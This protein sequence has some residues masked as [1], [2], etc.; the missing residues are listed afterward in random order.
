M[1]NINGNINNI[2]NNSY[3]AN[4]N[5]P[6]NNNGNLVTGNSNNGNLITG[7][8][9]TGNSNNGNLVTGNIVNPNNNNQP[10][11]EETNVG[12]SNQENDIYYLFVTAL[13]DNLLD[14]VLTY[15]SFFSYDDTFVMEEVI[16]GGH[17][18]LINLFMDMGY[19]I[20]MY[21]RN[22]PM[23]Y[24]ILD[25]ENELII[26]IINQIDYDDY[27]QDIKNKILF[28]MCRVYPNKMD[29]IN[30]LLEYSYDINYND[31][32]GNTYY[33]WA[34]AK[35]CLPL[36]NKLLEL[37]CN[38]E[39]LTTEQMKGIDYAFIYN[40]FDLVRELIK[41]GFKLTFNKLIEKSN[42]NHME[43][44][45]LIRDCKCELT[46]HM[47]LSAIQNNILPFITYLIDTH[48]HIYN[49]P[50]LF[51][52][53]KKEQ[54]EI[55][56]NKFKD[57]NIKDEHE[58]N[59]LNYA[60]H[61]MRYDI[62][63]DFFKYIDLG[64][65]NKK[66]NTPL[67]CLIN[68]DCIGCEKQIKEFAN[69]PGVNIFEKNN[70]N[71]TAIDYLLLY[72]RR[73]LAEEILDHYQSN[74]TMFWDNI[75][76]DIKVGLICKDRSIWEKILMDD[77]IDIKKILENT[78]YNRSMN[79]ILELGLIKGQLTEEDILNYETN[80]TYNF[81]DTYNLLKVLI[82]NFDKL[83]NKNILTTTIIRSYF[84]LIDYVRSI[85]LDNYYE[86]YQET[87]IEY[88]LEHLNSMKNILYVVN[89]YYSKEKLMQDIK[90]IKN[91]EFINNLINNDEI[92]KIEFLVRNGY[93]LKEDMINNLLSKDLTKLSKDFILEIIKNIKDNKILLDL[94]VKDN[95]NIMEILFNNA[96][97]KEITENCVICYGIENE[98]GYYYQCCHKH[99]YHF[100][101]LIP[102]LQK[103]NM[104]NMSC[105]F[106]K[107]DMDF[108]K[109][110]KQ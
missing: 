90:L 93:K 82:K 16:N 19:A 29:I 8:L 100:N 99:N 76:R 15:S 75:H 46:E 59:V 27:S 80:I 13:R 83:E 33:I 106:C 105:F 86:R 54:I 47:K 35:G 39:T 88:L 85:D 77:K 63:R 17:K 36:V 66:G 53:D 65:K 24:K 37:G 74:L 22:N 20:P 58:N 5:G 91:E 89:K 60:F 108:S 1:S 84:H 30:K 98:L 56:W 10:M 21:V 3:G 103:H 44:F 45:N 69:L 102:Y 92:Y 64:N 18:E 38:P 96:E 52:L 97:I 70:E 28:M 49:V 95:K 87:F 40:H 101:C 51:H 104:T 26:K 110:M 41:L 32:L 94:I 79:N 12:P 9:V 14:Q 48:T 25:Y 62:Y 34:C 109:I 31:N 68:R 72:N 4:L 6:H 23:I 7:N 55:Y 57:L 61:V 2:S 42:I 50:I 67:M 11:D 73:I 81:S 43:L 107:G 78:N 71:M